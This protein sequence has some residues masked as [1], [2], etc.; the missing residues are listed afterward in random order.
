MY[1]TDVIRQV[2]R[3]TRLPQRVVAEVLGT[4]HRLIEKTLRDGGSV[5]FPGFGTFRTT[6][7]QGGTVRNLATGKALKYPARRVAMFRVGDVL[8]RAVR[9]EKRNET[10]KP[11]A[12]RRSARKTA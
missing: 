1:K 11:T 10:R 2:A 12:A 3:D 8:K 5:T 9:G 7:R 4:T 6:E